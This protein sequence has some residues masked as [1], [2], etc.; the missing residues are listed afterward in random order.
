M[1][2]EIS[3]QHTQVPNEMAKNELNPKDQ[4]IYLAIKSFQNGQ[5]G[6]C[7]PSLQKIAERSGASIPTIRASIKRLEEKDYISIS[8]KGRSQEY[9]FSS[10]KNFEPFSKEFLEKEDLSFTTK[11]YLVASQQY[12]YQDVKGYGKI[13][14]PNTEL[15]EKINMPESTI[16]K[17]NQELKRKN[18]LTII[19][20]ES[21]DIETGCK[22][23]TKLFNLNELGQAVIWVLKSHE[24]RIN[25]HEDRLAK[26]E[27]E[28]EKQRKLIEKLLKEKETESVEFSI[29]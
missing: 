7:N 2:K 13:S 4:L 6:L 14:F 12:M 20:N 25:N 22:T 10:Y 29:I 16:R 23:E 18:Y 3:K 11:S 26:L 21:R 9:S 28:N 5:T 8:K 15:S 1:E 19:E 27:E 24:D 17:C